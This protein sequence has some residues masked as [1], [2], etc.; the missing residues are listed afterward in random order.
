M[1]KS[2]IVQILVILGLVTASQSIESSI[3][4]WADIGIVEQIRIIS[5]LIFMVLIFIS[6]LIIFRSVWVRKGYE[7]FDKILVDKEVSLFMSHVLAF[8]L[9]EVF[10]FM[11]IF[12]KYVAPPSYVFWICGAG[13]LSPEVIQIL[14]FVM[15]K[16]KSLKGKEPNE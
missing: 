2:L 4:Y 12:L 14:H 11:V 8:A 13:F 10:V 15:N 3:I 9:L 6:A 5:G 1:V 7:G 16:A